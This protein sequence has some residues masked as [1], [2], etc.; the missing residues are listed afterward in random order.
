MANI[1]SKNSKLIQSLGSKYRLVANEQQAV[2]NFFATQYRY[3][4][5]RNNQ[6]LPE[7]FESNSTTT[8]NTSPSCCSSNSTQ[9]ATVGLAL[10][11]ECN[12]NMKNIEFYP[13][14]HRTTHHLPRT[15]FSSINNHSQFISH[16]P[17]QYLISHDNNNL[18]EQNLNI[19]S[20]RIEAV[21]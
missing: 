15:Q 18:N 21:V 1:N 4:T 3:S 5:N 9:T 16:T 12:G 13:T 19:F 17:P 11:L 8:T 14:Q 2:P 7:Y 6:H 20:S 10:G